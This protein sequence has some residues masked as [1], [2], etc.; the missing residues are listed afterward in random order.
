MDL[1]S[2]TY[3]RF[4]FGFIGII[5]FSVAVIIIAG[6]FTHEGMVSGGCAGTECG[7]Q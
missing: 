7:T 6:K 5:L 3:F 2:K 1:F 4:A